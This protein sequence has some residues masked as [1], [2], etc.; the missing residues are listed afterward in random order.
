[1]ANM[2]PALPDVLPQ[3]EDV[4]FLQWEEAKD[5]SSGKGFTLF[6]VIVRTK[7]KQDI[8]LRDPD[9]SPTPHLW[10]P[11]GALD[12]GPADGHW[13][14]ITNPCRLRKVVKSGR[15]FWNL[16][17][18][19]GQPLADAKL[20]ATGNGGSFGGGSSSDGGNKVALSMEEVETLLVHFA[21]R[22]AQIRGDLGVSDGEWEMISKLLGI[23]SFSWTLSQ[24]EIAS[25]VGRGSQSEPQKEPDHI[26]GQDEVLD[27]ADDI[28]F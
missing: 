14:M 23:S 13:G 22:V 11:N 21:E 9:G 28:P 6:D 20:E 18:I 24:D 8:Q 26:P 19:E 4:L 7:S 3:T 16:D 12:F 25:L 15:A 1:M 5:S 10:L 27:D 17:P 2:R